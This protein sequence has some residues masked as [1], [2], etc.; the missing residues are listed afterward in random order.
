[1][2]A[3]RMRVSWGYK[4]EHARNRGGLPMAGRFFA[5][6]A[7]VAVLAIATPAA[8]QAQA[9]APT[10]AQVQT[11]TSGWNFSL[12]PYLWLPTIDSSVR[13]QLPN[14]V[15]VGTDTS[16]G[17]G[18]YI[19][20][21]HFAVALAGEARSDRFSVLTDFMYLS[22]GNSSSHIGSVNIAALPSNP[23]SS[24]QD[25]GTSTS[26][27]SAIWTLAG[28]YTLAQDAWGNVDVIGG[29]RLFTVTAKTDFNLAVQFF[30]PR[31]N[32]GPVFGG[33]GQLSAS[34][35]IWNG[36]AGVRG[37]INLGQSK[38][39]LPYYFDIGRGDS[40]LTW[41]VQAG[42]GYR[43]ASWADVSLGYRY[44]SFEQ[45]D[46]AIVRRLSLGGVLLN[47]TFHF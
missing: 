34:Q 28:G 35:D 31:G 2:I 27:K 18:D 6:T 30:G 47:A 40:K 29:F 3:G 14:Q 24:S 20:K 10:P 1:M 15:V 22:L 11:G 9:P 43:A 4:T 44:M 36:I 45:Y 8:A 16:V 46:S 32:A 7:S 5:V 23:I 33:S 13:Y 26:L 37:R 25:L 38:F 41:Q 17:P 19:D 39:F 42:V 21:L 12:T